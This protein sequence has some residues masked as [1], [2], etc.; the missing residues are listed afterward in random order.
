MSKVRVLVD[1]QGKPPRGYKR[2]VKICAEKILELVNLDFN[3]ELSVLLTDDAIMKRLNFEYRRIDETTDVLSFSMNE[4]ASLLSPPSKRYRLIG[5]IV[6]SIPQAMRQ[7]ENQ[8]HSVKH[9]L[10]FLTAHGILHLLGYDDATDEELA[11][12]AALGNSYIS[13]INFEAIT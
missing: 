11:E 4:G 6:I 5:D 13:R 9:E 12:M 8:K 2:F 10:A 7:A 3:C 1:I